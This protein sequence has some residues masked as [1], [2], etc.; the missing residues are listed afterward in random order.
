[1]GGAK[2]S[3]WQFV[4]Q[5]VGRSN[6]FDRRN[7]LVLGSVRI[8][9]GCM[10]VVTVISILRYTQVPITLV[11]CTL[12]QFLVLC[13]RFKFHAPVAKVFSLLL[14]PLGDQLLA[15]RVWR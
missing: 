4:L 6:G 7:D 10:N 8:G 5:N 15:E 9:M 13:S 1:V 14:L 11:S 2:A 12:F 3:L